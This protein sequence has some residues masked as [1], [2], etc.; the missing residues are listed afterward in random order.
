MRVLP[1]SVD[2]PEGNV[3]I[4]GSSTE[5][6]DDRL[7]ISWLFDNLI[8]RRLRFVNEIWIEDVELEDKGKEPLGRW[9]KY[10]HLISLYHLRRWIVGAKNDQ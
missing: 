6:Q 4:G 2:N 9:R 1:I 8:S 5:L 7:I 10:T 3:L